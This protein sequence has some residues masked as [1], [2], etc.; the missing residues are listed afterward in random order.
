M[1]LSIMNET[2]FII[3]AACLIHNVSFII[4]MTH[5]YVS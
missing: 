3:Y 1:K 5:S 2:L 4:D